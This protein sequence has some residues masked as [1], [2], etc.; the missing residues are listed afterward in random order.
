MNLANWLLRT[1]QRN[2]ERGAVFD[3]KDQTAT[4]G[5]LADQAQRYAMGLQMRG[6]QRG[7]R[8]AIFTPNC[9]EYLSILFA[10]WIAGG[11]AVPINAKLHPRE[12]AWII[13]NSGAKFAFVSAS[14]HADLGNAS[15]SAMIKIGGQIMLEM[16]KADPALAANKASQ[17]LAWLFYTSGTTGRPKG[18]EITHGM[19]ADVS[20]A[21]L[22][23]VD[24]TQADHCAIYAA[25][26]THGAGLYAFAH[27]LKGARHIIPPSRGFDPNEIFELCAHFSKASFFAAPTMVKRL[28][29]Y[30]KASGTTAP[31]LKTVIY[32]G[33]PMYVADIIEAVDALG[34]KFVQIYG[35]GECP[36]CITVMPRDIV[37]DRSHPNWQVRLGS[38]GVAQSI[39]EIRTVADGAVQAVGE[40]GEIQ[41]RSSAV[42]PGYWNNPLATAEALS[43]DWLNTGDMGALD[44]DGFLTL[45]DRSKDMIIS[46]GTNIYPRE[47][48]EAI[49]THAKV[50]EVAV[51]GRAHPEWGEEVIAIIVGN[52]RSTELDALCLSQIARFKRPK[53][54]YTISELPKN[55]YGKVV[56]T[57]LRDALAAGQLQ[58]LTG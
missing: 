31:G 8:V 58:E 39:C 54:Y 3:G 23:E 12:A 44:A 25:P 27:I 9:T 1:A 43:G 51:I 11:V 32:G 4:Y 33:G 10:I 22:A 24:E 30:A 35:Q 37:A 17:D 56:K 36:M 46:G 34:P 42:M 52:A 2:P 20:L 57:E 13:E 49:L 6:L 40:I 48:E 29:D 18:V 16:A 21:Y 14:H 26:M 28:V 45:H 15:P 53:A 47:I 55:N 7:D 38:V 5:A 41:V 19:L 50:Q